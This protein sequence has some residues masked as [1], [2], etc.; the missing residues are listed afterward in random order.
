MLFSDSLVTLLF[1]VSDKQAFCFGHISPILQGVSLIFRSQCHTNLLFHFQ[2]PSDF[3]QI[4][5]CPDMFNCTFTCVFVIVSFVY[6]YCTT[7]Q[8]ISKM[9]LYV[10]L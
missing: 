7:S 6:F 9:L 10:C 5:S 4:Y 1:C 2:S 3:Y 8:R